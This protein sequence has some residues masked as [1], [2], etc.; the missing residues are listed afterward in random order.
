MATGVDQEMRNQSSMIM[1]SFYFS[2]FTIIKF[3]VTAFITMSI[4]G[5]MGQSRPAR[6]FIES[7][8]LG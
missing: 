6:E 3:F 1:G 2:I 4:I 5:I 8:D 7:N